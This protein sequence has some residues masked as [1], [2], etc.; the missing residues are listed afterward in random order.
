MTA[1]LQSEAAALAAAGTP[2]PDLGR[3]TMAGI[4]MAIGTTT[5]IADIV[6]IAMT[7]GTLKD[8]MTDLAGLVHSET[9]QP[10]YHCFLPFQFHPEIPY[11]LW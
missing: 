8:D 10:N 7:A 4:S 3:G 2:D 5:E 6:G 9:A 11:F 1:L